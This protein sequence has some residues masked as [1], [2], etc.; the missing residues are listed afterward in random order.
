MAPNYWTHPIGWAELAA[1]APGEQD[2]CIDRI[3][4]GQGWP[5]AKIRVAVPGSPVTIEVR[6][7]AVEGG[8]RPLA[9]S[10]ILLV[11]EG[12]DAASK[13][14]VQLSKSAAVAVILA[15]AAAQ[16]LAQEIE[17]SD[18]DP[19]RRIDVQMTAW[20][21]PGSERNETLSVAVK[22]WRSGLPKF[23]LDIARR[24]EQ[25]EPIELRLPHSIASGDEHFIDICTVS[26]RF[27]R[28][29]RLLKHSTIMRRITVAIEGIDREIAAA[30]G[31]SLAIA[32]D[33]IDP[34]KAVPDAASGTWQFAADKL[35]TPVQ[36][37]PER[38]RI[39]VAALRQ[40]L[41][42][43]TAGRDRPLETSGRF[44]LDYVVETLKTAAA[45]EPATP[46]VFS[47]AEGAVPFRLSYDP[48]LSFA[49][50]LL[51]VRTTVALFTGKKAAPFVPVVAMTLPPRRA[52]AGDGLDA[53]DA[54][55]DGATSSSLT[56][57]T[58]IQ[59]RLALRMDGGQPGTEIGVKYRIE[60][61][62][63][64]WKALDGPIRFLPHPDTGFVAPQDFEI[65]LENLSAIPLQPR[66]HRI[67]LVIGL[68]LMP[69]GG[70]GKRDEVR[71]ELRL[72]RPRTGSLI[73]IDWGTSAVAAG[74]KLDDAFV[75]LP[76]GKVYRSAGLPYAGAASADGSGLAVY[77][78]EE[79]DDLIP[80]DMTLTPELNFRAKHRRFTYLDLRA[81]DPGDAG[82]LRR[83]TAVG[84]RHEVAL[85]VPS[86]ALETRHE[87]TV[88]QSLKMLLVSDKPVLRLRSGVPRRKKDTEIVVEQDV[89]VADLVFE[90]LDELTN[91]YLFESLQQAMQGEGIA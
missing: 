91:F 82:L 13:P 6:N 73:C 59:L 18:S 79:S 19:E 75:N 30:V 21:G 71:I 72:E 53:D 81:R 26:P 17:A 12:G 20:A 84:R 69:P 31:S 10:D 61:L 87:G 62:D 8:S 54:D 3:D 15:P 52:A 49:L 50:D 76:L 77:L 63:P 32:G 40:A 86:R 88:I 5:L 44:V 89:A 42:A 9:P 39:A 38:I 36:P 11:A 4:S 22:P 60:G 29:V 51:D 55:P 37:P 34:V 68:D 7:A 35:W 67:V 33:R 25:D 16:A 70:P 43:C 74:V 47:A 27:A 78:D 28:A 46:P 65:P 90:C 83:L 24:D 1:A 41:R 85:P 2:P 23:E 57:E 48:S 56:G 45:P 64:G 58:I 80:S 14:N 66:V